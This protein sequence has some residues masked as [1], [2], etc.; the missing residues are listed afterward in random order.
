[1][2][3]ESHDKKMFIRTHKDTDMLPYHLHSE[4]PVQAFPS[5]NPQR[6]PR[7]RIRKERA[8]PLAEPARGATFLQGQ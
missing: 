5:P 6:A 3:R 1:M 7:P 4:L 2:N 8:G